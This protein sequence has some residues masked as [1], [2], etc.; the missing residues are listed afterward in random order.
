[1][2]KKR[3]GLKI[4][5]TLIPTLL[6][7][8]IILQF[9]IISAVQKSS[10]EQSKG[11]LEL[12]SYS[13]FQ[14]VRAAMNLGDR[15]LIEK[16]LK[17]ASK[18]EGINELSIH[19]DQSVIDTFGLNEKPSQEKLI[20]NLLKNPKKI[21]QEIKDDKGHRLRVL[22]P[23]IATD[24]CL[25][26]HAL[27][28]KGDVLG[29]MDLDYSFKSIDAG[30]D[31][32]SWNLLS[33]FI[34]FLLLTSVVVM[35]VMKKVVGNPVFELLGRTRDLASGDSDLTKRVKVSSEDEIGLVGNNVNIFIEKIQEVLA[36]SQNIARSVD[37]NGRVL[38]LNADKIAKSA[39]SQ[40]QNISTTFE[41]MKNVEKDLAHSEELS[42]NTA[43]DNIASFEILE[44]MSIALN[45]VVEKVFE[46]SKSEQEMSNQIQTVV[47]QTEQIKGVLEMI[48]DIADQTNLLALNAAI[49]AARAGEHGRGFAVVA[50]EVRKLAERTQK[51]LAEIDATIS[52][53]VQG[54]MQ[55]SEQ[56]ERN[57]QYMQE[58]STDAQDVRNETEKT[59]EKTKESIEV[60]KEASKK[61]VEI[62]HLTKVM[63]GQMTE[64]FEASNDNEKI[65]EELA[66]IS[67]QMA[68]V[69]KDLDDTLSL[70]KV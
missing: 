62:S 20:I 60:S 19:K 70:F 50:D 24:E 21:E 13:V 55:L 44:S 35:F 2:I 5:F 10:V 14:T 69:S 1:M 26:C 3:I 38:E 56:L 34:L 58:V 8:F 52:V 64:T 6:I 9:F 15:E 53:I 4:A 32:I 43:E 25:A 68:H 42:I 22:T 67:E 31:S 61:V 47:Q 40:T 57:A 48:K 45:N 23:L 39:I 63:M 16:S 12:L 7:S 30:I 27:N 33:I 66:K 11:S 28:K 54:V 37:E 36:K 18:M 46:S 29:V 65:A 49:E 51:S 59:K 17:D 41:V